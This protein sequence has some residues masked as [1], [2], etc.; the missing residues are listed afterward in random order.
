MPAQRRGIAENVC[1]VEEAEKDETLEQRLKR[2]REVLV[3]RRG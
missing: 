3:R 1:E 2:L